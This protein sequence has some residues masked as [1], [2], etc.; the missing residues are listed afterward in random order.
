MLR[1]GVKWAVLAAAWVAGSLPCLAQKPTAIPLVP[2]ANWRLAE[3]QTVPFSALTNYGGEPAVEQEYGL[4]SL[5]HRTY[6]LAGQRVEVV[7][8]TV[9]DASAA[10]G[11][12]TY[13]Q[14]PSMM[15]AK[16]IQL[17]VI[18]PEGALMARGPN[19]IRFSPAPRSS[20]TDNDWRALLIF[21]GGTRP[22]ANAL[23]RIPA[24][25]PQ[26]GLIPGSEKYLLGLEAARRIL[27][28]FRTDLIGFTQGAEVQLANYQIGQDRPTL[29]AISYPTPQ[30][31]RMRYG[32][33]SNFLGLNQAQGPA[34]IYGR[35][36]G[37]YVFLVLN[38]TTPMTAT[39]LL[40]FFQVSQKVSWNERYPGD[41]P[42]ALQVLELILANI[43]LILILVGVC[44]MGGIL[45]F[46]SKRLAHKYLPDWEWGDPEGESLIRLNLS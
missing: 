35:R 2:A 14:T 15:A 3:S 7:L 41:K 5:V 4:K 28:S 19:F 36:G 23:P 17:A 26:T 8:E 24:P 10:Y 38:A 6:E 33:M 31:A 18:G 37:S 43:M 39:N 44:I 30:I 12:F 34:S 21:V 1:G 42:F 20:L 29:V 9:P 27:P 11:L 25:L 13:Y 46:L 22:S 16:G 32:A 45:V 40:N